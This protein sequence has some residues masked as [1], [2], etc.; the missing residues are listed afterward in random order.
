MAGCGQTRGEFD[1]QDWFHSKEFPVSSEN[2]WNSRD[3]SYHAFAFAG[4]M[5]KLNT[6]NP[7]VKA[8]LLKVCELLD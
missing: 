5:P 1:L 4:Y 8:Y 6:A 2:L 3:L 7:E